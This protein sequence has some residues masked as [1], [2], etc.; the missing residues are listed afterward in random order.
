MRGAQVYTPQAVINGVVMVTGSDRAAIERAIQQ[1]DRDTTAMQLPVK[2][3]IE[4]EKLTVEVSAS[5]DGRGQGE[6]WLCPM[7]NKVP[8]K[9]E[10]GE[11]NGHV[12]TYNNVVRSW[13][14]LG[15]W[16]GGA[17]TYNLSITDFQNANF[18]SVVVIVQSGDKLSPGLM[19]GASTAAIR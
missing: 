12:V 5:S 4:G 8:V 13:V 10:R 9:I 15:N 19:L 6:V 11:N 7:V 3:T 2:L 1:T 17:E 16:S 18:D 14:K